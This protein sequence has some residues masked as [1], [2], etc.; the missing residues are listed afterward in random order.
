MEFIFC[1]QIN[2]KFAAHVQSTQK[3]KLVIFLQYVNKKNIDEGYF[4]R[5]DKYENSLQVDTNIWVY[6][7]K[8]NLTRM[9]KYFSVAT[10]FVFYCDAKHSDILWGPSHVCCSFFFLINFYFYFYQIYKRNC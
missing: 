8:Q 7:A 10:T 1:M 5:A 4:F 9:I 6:F 2:M 3:K